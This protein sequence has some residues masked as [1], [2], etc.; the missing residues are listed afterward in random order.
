[1][2]AFWNIL[3]PQGNKYGTFTI[4]IWGKEERKSKTLLIIYCRFF[5]AEIE[6]WG[7]EFVTNTKL[8]W[9]LTSKIQDYWSL[10]SPL[11]FPHTSWKIS[12]TYTDAPL[13]LHLPPQNPFLHMQTGSLEESLALRFQPFLTPLLFSFF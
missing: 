10:E 11:G 5:P 3:M 8:A 13:L 2:F 7:Q 12:P 1:M 4:F 9:M 6:T